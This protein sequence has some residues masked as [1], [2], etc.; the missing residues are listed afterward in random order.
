[1]TFH[2]DNWVRCSRKPSLE[3]S[4]K[5]SAS[6]V[7]N[8]D[9]GPL[10]SF[11]HLTVLSSA[12]ADVLYQPPRLGSSGVRVGLCLES[13]ERSDDAAGRGREII[14]GGVGTFRSG[15]MGQCDLAVG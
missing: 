7:S 11:A 14:S 1:M 9:T 3:N 15:S 2:G 5:G 4:Q 12:D 10:V 13:W 8:S 6:A